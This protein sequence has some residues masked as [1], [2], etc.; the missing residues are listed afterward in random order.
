V[1]A[2]ELRPTSLQDTRF[3]PARFATP[4]RVGERN[5]SILIPPQL[6]GMRATLLE[7]S[8]IDC[9]GHGPIANIVG[10]EMVLRSEAR[11]QSAGM[12][13]IAQ[14]RVEIDHAIERA[15]GPDPF[16]N[17]L[18]NCFLGFRVVARNVYTFKRT[19][20]GANQLDP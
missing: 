5:I 7:N 14:N 19:D 9:V 3:D 1:E 18:P 8:E 13:R 2:V 12:I 20:R 15:A 16:V 11:Q 4:L 10:M 6:R 17:R